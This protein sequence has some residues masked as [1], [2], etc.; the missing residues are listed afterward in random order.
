MEL[1]LETIGVTLVAILGVSVGRI[2]SHLKKPYW[3]FGYFLPLALVVILVITQ[4][5]RA[6]SFLPPLSW[7]V[8]GELVFVIL[9]LA[10]TMGLTTLLPHLP[11]KYERLITC[12]LMVVF[13]AR[14]SVSP[15]IAPALCKDD[16]SNLQ[17]TIDVDGICVQSRDYTCGP[18]AAVTALKKLGFEAQEGEI[19]VLARTSPITGTIPRCLY[20]ALQNRYGYKGL[21][22]Q[23]RYFDSISQLKGKGII[24][25]IV[26]DAFLSNHCV[27]VI[28][29]SDRIVVLADPAFG[30]MNVSHEQFEKIWRFSG[31]V[32]KRDPAP[33]SV[34]GKPS[35]SI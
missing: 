26:K 25:A 12:V 28:E 1:G 14:F 5:I 22:C 20:T 29:V 6:L 27:A 24:L 13:V 23:Y 17:T 18:A 35:K 34:Q 7:L 16:L 19:A 4:H 31:I 3:I 11:H 33:V 30:K 2:F 8:T 10:I 21:K 32:L 15:F 9:A